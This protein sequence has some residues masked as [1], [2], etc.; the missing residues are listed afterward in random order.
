[1]IRCR[2]DW[3]HHYETFCGESQTSFSRNATRAGSEEG[4]LFSLAKVIVASSHI[5]LKI[6]SAL[7]SKQRTWC[8]ELESCQL[9]M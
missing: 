5:M 2:T 4:R 6:Q 1:M 9:F 3:R 8:I 7:V